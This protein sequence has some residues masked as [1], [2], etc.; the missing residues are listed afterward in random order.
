MTDIFK[1]NSAVELPQS[2]DDLAEDY[3]QTREFL[4]HCETWNPCGQIYAWTESSG[5]CTSWAVSYRLRLDIFTY[6]G[7]KSPISMQIIG[8]PCSVSASG[9]GGD[10]A[11]AASCIEYLTAE[12]RSS[13][14]LILNSAES[15]DNIQCAKGRTFPN[16]LMEPLAPSWSVYLASLRSSY[17]RWVASAERST[18]KMTVRLEPCTAFS[19]EHYKQYLSVLKKSSGRLETLSKDFFFHLNDNFILESMYDGDKLAGWNICAYWNDR[20]YFFLVGM[21]YALRDIHS[22][23]FAM[24]SSIV[25]RACCKSCISL[26][27]GQTT[28]SV[29]MRFGG[30]II[31]RHMAAVHK[32]RLL[33]GVL[34]ICAPLMS[35]RKT[36]PLYHVFSS[37]GS[38]I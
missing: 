25:K 22:T 7:I 12:S 23:Y 2:W 24:L 8:I 18:E 26:D 28:E 4:L 3:F 36:P 38:N 21:D 29:K 27:L 34:K 30:H 17:R 37:E 32:N 15:I 1:V 16:V 35:Y 19:E 31:E 6:L 14:T 11:L 33:L 9:T 10:K 20:A 5:S 13:F